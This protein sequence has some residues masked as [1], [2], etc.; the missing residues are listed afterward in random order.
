M[1]GDVPKSLFVLAPVGTRHQIKTA[2]ADSSGE[3]SCMGLRD[4]GAKPATI[5]AAPCDTSAAGQL[6]TM[7][8]TGRSDGDLPAYTIGAAGG[9]TLQDKGVGGLVAA[10]GAG[11]PFVLVDNGPSTLPRL[12]D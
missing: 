4:N 3:P 10:T 7:K 11:S 6:F 12:G 1:E 5:V 9:R 8:K 2:E